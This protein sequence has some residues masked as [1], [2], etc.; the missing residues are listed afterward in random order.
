M[1]VPRPARRQQEQPM[2]RTP[3]R[4]GWWR[5]LAPTILL[6]ALGVAIPPALEFG[7]EGSPRAFEAQ[8]QGREFLGQKKIGQNGKFVLMTQ[9][10][11]QTMWGGFSWGP[12]IAEEQKEAE[13]KVKE[14][15]KEHQAEIEK[16]GKDLQKWAKDNGYDTKQK[17]E[18]SDAAPLMIG[19]FLC[20]VLAVVLGYA[21]PPGRLRTVLFAG[22]VV[23]AGLCFGI[24]TAVGFPLANKAEKELKEINKVQDGVN[25]LLRVA[26]ASVEVPKPYVRYTPWFYLAW[27]FLLLPVGVVAVEEVA[28]LFAGGGKRK[29]PRRRFE[30]ND[31]ED[32]RPRVARKRR[33]HELD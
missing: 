1:T 20:V 11:Y 33:Y 10:E 27:P 4:A 19:Y 12:E 22:A 5:F 2:P 7:S 30:D 23:A 32:E 8:N 24:Q 16:L 29:K 14:W 9:N 3:Q 18:E 25:G 15:A 21:M 31:D 28:A 26:G 17:K 13:R 6:V